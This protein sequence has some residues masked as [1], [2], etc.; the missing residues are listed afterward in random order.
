MPTWR[1][2]GNAAQAVQ[3]HHPDAGGMLYCVLVRLESLKQALEEADRKADYWQRQS[4]AIRDEMATLDME[5]AAL[6]ED[7]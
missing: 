2:L 3:L 5:R 7:A 6:E 4:Q 1:D